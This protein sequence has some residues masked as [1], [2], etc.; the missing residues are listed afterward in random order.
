[1]KKNLKKVEKKTLKETFY[2]IQNAVPPNK[3]AHYDGRE[4]KWD[5][6]TFED[7]ASLAIELLQD[8]ENWKKF[9]SLKTN[10]EKV[11]MFVEGSKKAFLLYHRLPDEIVVRKE[12]AAFIDGYYCGG[13]LIKLG[14]KYKRK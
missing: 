7:Y 3:K 10:V 8:E 14:G 13:S 5:S 6:F 2:A 12:M 11:Y 4:L 1:M 9:Y